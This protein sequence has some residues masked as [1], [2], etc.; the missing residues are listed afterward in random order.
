MTENKRKCEVIVRLECES[1]DGASHLL[2]GSMAAWS[3]LFA[4]ALLSESEVSDV[5]FP[6]LVLFND[7]VPTVQVS[8]TP[9]VSRWLSTV[10]KDVKGSG[11]DLLCG[12]MQLGKPPE[13]RIPGVLVHEPLYVAVVYAFV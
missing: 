8:R 3:F 11:R 13:I 2:L 4:E 7:I 10:V 12:N 9:E 5:F 1:C 6:P